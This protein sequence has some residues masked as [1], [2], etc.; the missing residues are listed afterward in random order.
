MREKRP[1]AR[2][3]A[4]TTKSDDPIAAVADALEVSK[5]GLSDAEMASE[6]LPRRITSSHGM[7]LF[8]PGTRI[9]T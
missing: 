8:A 5:L 2:P 1:C 6:R 9:P 3:L 4:E 7:P